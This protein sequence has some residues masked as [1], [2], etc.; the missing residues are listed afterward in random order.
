MENNLI[1][2]GLEKT[3][4]GLNEILKELKRGSIALP[5]EDKN[6]QK[7]KVASSN[8]SEQLSNMRYNELRALARD[9]GLDSSGTKDDIINR[10]QDNTPVKEQEEPIIE[11]EQV[12]QNE[13]K[14]LQTKVEV[15]VVDMSVEELG[16]LLISVGVKPKG[17]RQA[18][19]ALLV[20]A[21]EDGLVD[22]EGEDEEVAS[23]DSG[24]E[25]D[26]EVQSQ[27]VLYNDPESTPIPD[28]RLEGMEVMRNQIGEEIKNK[29]IS[30][31]DIE[32]TLEAFYLEEAGDEVYD[33]GNLSKVEKIELYEEAMCRMIDDAGE[34]QEFQ[35][36]Y[37]LNG[38]DAC[39]GHLL[40]QV[41]DKLY[42][43][44]CGNEYE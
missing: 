14:D 23:E 29:T 4:E 39:C 30:M 43:E 22:L 33:I 35:T 7:E 44:L 16:E 13:E 25:E 40:K 5:L 2:K 27:N 34:S 26:E 24:A 1:T 11:D 31:E 12:Q 38:K 20:K 21:V 37:K 18:L 8:I 36:P 42:C 32:E 17:K 19:I 15:A 28:E 9:R 3:I 10:L 41:S 6:V